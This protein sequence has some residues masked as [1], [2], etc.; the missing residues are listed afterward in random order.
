MKRP[1]IC[2]S[3][4]DSKLNTTRIYYDNESYFDY[5]KACGGI[6]VL[7]GTVT[8]EEAEQIA[9]S[10]D[11]LVVT[12][13]G[14][15]DPALY[16]EENTHSEIVE[17][18]IDMSDILLYK[19]FVKAGKPVLGICRGIQ[20]INIA[21][22]GSLIQDIPSESEGY[23]EHNQRNLPDHP[24]GT[25]AHFCTFVQGSVL[26]EIF[27]DSHEVNT[28]H[29]Q[30]IRRLAEGFCASAYSTD[31]LIEGIEKENVT[32]VQW[33][34]ERLIHDEKHLRLMQWF[35]EQCSAHQTR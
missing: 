21:E 5:V 15:C 3:A 20:L 24:V 19:A 1:L 28:Y 26:H 35:I 14:D 17:H 29:H 9:G 11:G 25:T 16:G 18:D 13:G 4:R 23:M 2:L 6:P 32:A 22:G 27:S 7:A 8:E 10:F 31:G 12:G 33:H 30:A 34:P